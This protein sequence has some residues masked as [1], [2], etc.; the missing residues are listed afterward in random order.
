MTAHVVA[1]CWNHW[2]VSNEIP[3]QVYT[4]ALT[5]FTPSILTL[6]AEFELKTSRTDSVCAKQLS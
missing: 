6:T 3:K 4:Q 1:Y 5:Q 2:Q